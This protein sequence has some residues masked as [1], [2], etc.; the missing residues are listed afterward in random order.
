[1]NSQKIGVE[2]LKDVVSRAVTKT[3]LD[4]F[5]E[6]LD[7]LVRQDEFKQLENDL[8]FYAKLSDIDSL[9]FRL[10]SVEKNTGNYVH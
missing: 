5:A 4:I 10:D 6:R 9:R 8:N 1:M 3:D 7:S 2:L